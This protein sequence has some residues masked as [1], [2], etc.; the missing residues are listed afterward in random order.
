MA[1][2]YALIRCVRISHLP[3][4]LDLLPLIL[5]TI[6]ATARRADII[7]DVIAIPMMKHLSCEADA[8][9]NWYR[10]INRMMVMT[11]YQSILI[12]NDDVRKKVI[13]LLLLLLSWLL[14]WLLLL[15]LLLFPHVFFPSSPKNRKQPP[16]Q[17]W[18][19]H[20]SLISLVG[21]NHQLGQSEHCHV[22]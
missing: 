5:L 1:A 10:L 20:P 9:V 4:F 13:L 6:A 16:A 21:N 18:K 3:T 12:M 7:S 8:Q 19:N 11:I 15:L 17:D 22:T 14:L 2:G